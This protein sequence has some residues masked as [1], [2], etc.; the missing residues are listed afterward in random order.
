MQRSSKNFKHRKYAKAERVQMEV[1]DESRELNDR[2]QKQKMPLLPSSYMISPLK[3]FYSIEN[4]Y[5][6]TFQT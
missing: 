4:G 3:L 1:L 5:R 6:Q 2:S